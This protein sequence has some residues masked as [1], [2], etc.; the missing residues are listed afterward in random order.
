MTKHVQYKNMTEHVHIIEQG[1]S[2]FPCLISQN[3]LSRAVVIG[4]YKVVAQIRQKIPITRN[5][6]IQQSCK[7]RSVRL[8]NE[9]LL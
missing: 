5:R 6:I 9:A 7:I 3:S 4:L 2:R 1:T 8:K